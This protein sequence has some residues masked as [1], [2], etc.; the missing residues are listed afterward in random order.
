MLNVSNFQ[1]IIVEVS[2][3]NT[4]RLEDNPKILTVHGDGYSCI[5]FAE[6]IREKYGYD[7][8][9]PDA[10]EVIEI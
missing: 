3:R 7:A 4:D 2:Y 9:A 6:E 8:K 1:G 5:K 10:G